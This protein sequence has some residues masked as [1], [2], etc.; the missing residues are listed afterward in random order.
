MAFILTISVS[1]S[2]LLFCILLNA[3][4]YLLDDI[5]EN[6]DY[7]L[8]ASKKQ[9]KYFQNY[10]NEYSI[11]S[12]DSD[13]IRQWASNN[14]IMYFT[15]SKDRMLIFDNSY[16]G[17]IPLNQTLSNQLNNTWMYFSKV[18]FSDGDA[19]V[20]FYKNTEKK[21]YILAE[22]FSALIA[23]ISGYLFFIFRIKSEIKYIVYLSNEVEKME[24]DL[25]S[26]Y[27]TQIGNDEISTLANALETM[28]LQLVDKIQNE[29]NMKKAQDNLV[30]SMAH[31]IRTPLT[32][33]IAYIEIIKRQNSID[34][35]IIYSN[36]ALKQANHIKNLSDQLFDLFLINSGQ[37]EIIEAVS[38]TEYAFGDYFSELY[39]YLQCQ[40]YNLN[41]S[42]L[43]WNKANISICFDYIG[44]IINNIQ[45]NIIKYADNK[46]PILIYSEI[47]AD[48][49][50]IIIENTIDTKLEKNASTGIGVKNIISMMKKMDGICL[51]ETTNSI[52]KMT[53]Q[54]NQWT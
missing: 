46:Y 5:F 34:E 3:T 29:I 11:S 7:R 18:T 37:K 53:L 4:T 49:F 52:Y 19:D 38:N 50:S 16:N 20:F 45:S 41:V 13:L 15:I 35:T 31:D 27:F 10:V 33:L 51:I 44:R 12:S 32:S 47:T 23:I 21:Y 17:A 14:K 28:R 42:K 26:A 48:Y 6:T 30:L 1:I 9:A 2:L 24:N 8:N 22:L 36:K 54:F 39:N 25:N 40:N 43:S